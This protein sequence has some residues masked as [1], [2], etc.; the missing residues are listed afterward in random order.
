MGQGGWVGGKAGGAWTGGL[1]C[2][3]AYCL[4]AI[5]S[6]GL[7]CGC[8]VTNETSTQHSMRHPASGT[9]CLPTPA[10]KHKHP[11]LLPSGA[12]AH[13]GTTRARQSCRHRLRFDRR[14]VGQV[15]RQATR[16]SKNASSIRQ[17]RTRTEHN[18]PSPTQLLFLSSALP[19]TRN[20]TSSC[21]SLT[22][23][24]RHHRNGKP[25]QLAA[26]QVLHVAVHHLW[27]ASGG[28]QG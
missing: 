1:C 11:P 25:L 22:L 6:A 26:R 27:K 18:T 12:A 14:V 24:R 3:N 28:K 10:H 7:L 19:P 16:D 5:W 23:L 17:H 13:P 2:G 4:L 21:P 20:L 9:C 8:S 15:G